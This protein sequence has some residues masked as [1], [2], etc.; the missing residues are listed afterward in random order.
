MSLIAVRGV[1]NIGADAVTKAYIRKNEVF[2]DA[3]NYFMYNGE[4]KILPEQLR[5]LDT[6]EIAIL[7]NEKDTKDNKDKEAS[8]LKTVQKYRDLMKT[9]TIMEDGEA[10]YVLLGIE[11]QTEV[12]YA[13]PVRNMLYDAMQYNQQVADIAATYKK[14]K[15]SKIQQKRKMSNGEFL[16][17]FHKDDKL[18][19]VITLVLFFNA[20]AWD[21]PRSLLDMMD[22]S[23][24]VVRDMVVDYP[25]HLIE[26][27]G[28]LDKDLEKFSSS[29][30]EVIGCIKY[31]NDKHKLTAFI[32]D[33]PRMNM[34]I[35]A[36]RV[37]ETITSVIIDGREVDNMGNVNMCKAI[38]DMIQDVVD[39]KKDDWL[40][41]GRNEGRLTGLSEGRLAGL[42]EGK[43]QLLSTLIQSGDISLQK[44][45]ALM[46]MTPEEF[47]AK[48]K[49][50]S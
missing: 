4:Q 16:S 50:I 24:S 31:S 40:A 8:E 33:N 22:I 38:E 47:L 3:F 6:T 45:A 25:L 17:G 10:A 13:M 43:M 12:H 14:E 46:N 21:G 11:N 35:E 20:K 18:I 27:M 19:P 32:H 5:E 48:S 44:A 30:R 41:E 1:D 28:I 15:G 2:A 37:I 42:S 34:E 29:L 36:A 9:A 23:N 7:L 49:T 39:E 26:P